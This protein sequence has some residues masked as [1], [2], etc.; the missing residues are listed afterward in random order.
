MKSEVEKNAE[1]ATKTAD[2]LSASPAATPTPAPTPEPAEDDADDEKDKQ[3]NDS[4]TPSTTAGQ[5]KLKLY[6]DQNTPLGSL[7]DLVSDVVNTTRESAARTKNAI[8]SKFAAFKEWLSPTPDTATPSNELKKVAMENK[9]V[10]EPA[11]DAVTG[12]PGAGKVATTVME[13]EEKEKKSGAAPEKGM[14]M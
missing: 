7:N 1:E 8:T 5:D 3:Q 11:I 2:S 10:V 13:S 12:V 6:N 9:E 14:G 4:S